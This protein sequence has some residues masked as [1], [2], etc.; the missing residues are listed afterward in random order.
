MVDGGVGEGGVGEGRVGGCSKVNG[1]RDSMKYFGRGSLTNS[2]D[3]TVLG[4][5]T[6]SIFSTIS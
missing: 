5:S 1:R 2:R 6:N 3:L 4:D